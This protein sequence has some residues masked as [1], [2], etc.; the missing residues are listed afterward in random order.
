MLPIGSESTQSQIGFFSLLHGVNGKQ[1]HCCT[2][3]SH[4]FL[5]PRLAAVVMQRGG[6]VPEE[7]YVA[8]G[9]RRPGRFRVVGKQGFCLRCLWCGAV[10]R[11]HAAVPACA[12]AP[13]WWGQKRMEGS[14]APVGVL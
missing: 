7:T 11:H 8:G 6:M 2:L 3:K 14:Q 4:W 13:A 5:M 12:D 1:D 9:V 10:W